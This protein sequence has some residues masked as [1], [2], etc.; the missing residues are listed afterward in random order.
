MGARGRKR[1]KSSRR[2][3]ADSGGNEATSSGGGRSSLLAYVLIVLAAGATFAGTL[4]AG[5]VWDDI[6]LIVTNPLMKSAGSLPGF[7]TSDIFVEGDARGDYYRPLF[8][9]TLLM[10]SLAYGESAM[11]FHL[12]NIFLH[13][14]VSVCVFRLTLSLMQYLRGGMAESRDTVIALVAA[15]LFSVHPLHAEPV[16]WISGREEL[17]YTFFALLSAVYFIKSLDPENRGLS[18]LVV[19]VLCFFAALLSKESAI[20]LPAVLF[21]LVLVGPHVSRK[22]L[23]LPVFHLAAAVLYFSIRGLVLDASPVPTETTFGERLLTAPW[24]FVQYIKLFVWPFSYRILHDFDY[25]QGMGDWRFWFPLLAAVLAAAMLPVFRK[26]LFAETAGRLLLFS[27]GVYALLIAPVLGIVVEIQP[28]P[29][30][31]RYAYAPSLG[32]IL[33]LALGC[34]MLLDFARE[35]GFMKMLPIPMAAVLL[36]LAALSWHRASF[37]KNENVFFQRMLKDAPNFYQ[38]Y[39]NRGR[40]LYRARN[41]RGALANF[42]RAAQLEKRSPSVQLNL[43][44]THYALGDMLAA[45]TALLQAIQ[46]RPDYY[47]PYFN[48]GVL[49]TRTGRIDDARRNLETVL[50]LNPGHQS[51]RDRLKRL[52]TP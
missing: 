25:V 31:E 32:L 12:A 5:F 24:V 15:L 35:R 20:A 19:S 43:G 9:T 1:N 36:V 10:D 48:L 34:A 13:V 14:L 38:G 16:A 27:A 4:G 23:M 29:L 18:D 42:Q 44:V 50:K 2:A 51:A 47:R 33:P 21:L 41:Y 8:L 26:R 39:Y 37:W 49:Y 46:L 52:K 17:L 6:N 22:R 7:F 45:E 11:G 40:G 3:A 30:A 28:V